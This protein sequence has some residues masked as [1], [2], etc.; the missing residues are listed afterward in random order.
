[1]YNK[2]NMY[3][4]R[5]DYP[6][7]K[8]E[9]YTYK[10]VLPFC[11]KV[12]YMFEKGDNDI[13]LNDKNLRRNFSFYVIENIKHPIISY[14]VKDCI[15]DIYNWNDNDYSEKT[16]NEIKEILKQ[17]IGYSK[18]ASQYFDYDYNKRIYLKLNKTYD[19][20]DLRYMSTFLVDNLIQIR[21]KIGSMNL[22]KTQMHYYS[23]S[24]LKHWSKTTLK[25]SNKGLIADTTYS[26]T[27]H[28]G[29]GGWTFGGITA[30]DL[31]NLC[32][33]NG[34]KKEK[35]KK[36]QY[37]DYANWYLHKLE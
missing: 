32:I 12:T 10:Y 13:K 20:T 29:R 2:Y 26:W 16:I 17:H 1:M 37:G 4:K 22:T 19:E 30:E 33:E 21:V 23:P 25:P 9:M 34:F 15:E 8:G 36:Y 24:N 11:N 3:G 5:F 7:Y 6:T 18:E 14:I 28:W 35:K 27:E 31:E